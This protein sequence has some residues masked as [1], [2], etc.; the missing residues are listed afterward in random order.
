M[1]GFRGQAW[2]ALGKL[3]DR[4]GSVQVGFAF[5]EGDTGGLLLRAWSGYFIL[6]VERALNQITLS[7]YAQRLFLF[8]RFRDKVNY[9]VEVSWDFASGLVLRLLSGRKVLAVSARNA[10][11]KP[12]GTG[13][14]PIELGGT[15]ETCAPGKRSFK[16]GFS[17]RILAFDCFSQPLSAPGIPR[18]SRRVER[19]P[20]R[21]SIPPATGITILELHD[22][23]VVESRLRYDTIPD[24][25][26]NYRAFNRRHPEFARA[27]HAAPDA[28]EGLRAIGKMVSELWPHTG[29]CPDK[30]R[31]IFFERGDTLLADIKAGKTAGMCGG[32]AHVMEEVCWALGIP[33]RRTQVRDH[34]SFEVY[35]HH[36]DKW[37]CMET[38]P[39]QDT[40]VW[41]NPEGVPMSIG[42]CIAVNE[43]DALEPGFF[44]RHVRFLSNGAQVADLGQYGGRMELWFRSCY[45]LMFY[46]RRDDYHWPKSRPQPICGY[47][48]PSLRQFERQFTWNASRTDWVRDWRELYWSC[49]RVRVTPR[50]REKGKIIRLD[51]SAVQCQFPAGFEVMVDGGGWHAQRS[52]FF[53]RLHDGVNLVLVRTRNKQGVAGRP[54]RCA[55]HRRPSCPASLSWIYGRNR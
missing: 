47:V 25:L 44:A 40:G 29:Y 19:V 31:K 10:V 5:S 55:I 49:D 23:P 9:S 4:R 11:W 28:F 50:W 41:L 3:T 22:P 39:A 21:A 26:A 45:H 2:K 46:V 20:G 18:I 16:P 54:W 51:F 35:D 12:Y 33:A 38:D 24:R 42:E 1:S 17:G 34:S 15:L 32:Y 37:I 13:C 30:P 6:R 52:P 36:H 14:T 53:W 8:W 27:F 48:S 7:A 43:R